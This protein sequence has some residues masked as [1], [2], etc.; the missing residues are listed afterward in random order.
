MIMVIITNHLAMTCL[1]MPREAPIKLQIQ[2]VQLLDV[3]ATNKL[4]V[5][6]IGTLHKWYNLYFVENY[7]V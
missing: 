6:I 2:C 5:T 3:V 1:R 4:E 7:Y